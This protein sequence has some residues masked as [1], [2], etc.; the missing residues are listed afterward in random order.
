MDTRDGREPPAALYRVRWQRRLASGRIEQRSTYV[1]ATSK[2]RALERARCI[3]R[4][5]GEDFELLPDGV[6]IA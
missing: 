3:V 4:H 1:Q 2:E 5:D 6:E